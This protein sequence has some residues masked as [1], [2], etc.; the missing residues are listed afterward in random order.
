MPI[1][2]IPYSFTVFHWILVVLRPSEQI[3]NNLR[4]SLKATATL[5]VRG[6]AS[7]LVGLSVWL[8]QNYQASILSKLVEV[9][10]SYLIALIFFSAES[11]INSF[12]VGITHK[13]KILVTKSV[14]VR[15]DWIGERRVYTKVSCKSKLNT[16]GNNFP[17]GRRWFCMFCFTTLISPFSFRYS[18]WIG[19]VKSYLS[20]YFTCTIT[21]TAVV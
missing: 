3:T 13:S 21:H 20:F 1:S 10:C 17:S 2:W 6:W 16:T 11:I 19:M 9:I 12:F 15:T 18:E 14:E 4:P 7:R 8:K 5:K